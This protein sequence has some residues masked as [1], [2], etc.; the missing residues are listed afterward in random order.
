MAVAALLL[1]RALAAVVL[2]VLAWTGLPALAGH[3]I[4]VYITAAN[5]D[6]GF[7][8]G[9]TANG[10]FS[11]TGKNDALVL[12]CRTSYLQPAPA[13]TVAAFWR[14][15]A[16]TAVGPVLY[17]SKT[18]QWELFDFRRDFKQFG[19]D[20]TLIQP[21]DG[22]VFI[23][24]KDE[25]AFLAGTEFDKLAYR[26]VLPA[27]VVL[28]SGVA[29]PGELVK[30][31]KPGEL[32]G[33]NSAMLCIAGGGIVAGFSDGNVERMTEGRYQTQV[34]EVSATFRYIGGI[35]QYIAVPA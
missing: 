22:G 6:D 19:A 23:G 20:I 14:G 24:T 21:V 2:T 7:Y 16:L 15:R 18:N 8:A 28:G 27:G 33:Q 26:R 4:K 5:G 29:A 32:P 30:R 17:A 25:L 12:P 1:R 13:G 10:L 11:Y 34:A 31:G 9:N 3:S 35:P